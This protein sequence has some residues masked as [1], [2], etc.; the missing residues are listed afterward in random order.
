MMKKIRL[1]QSSRWNGK[2]GGGESMKAAQIFSYNV[3][4]IL[5]V[6]ISFGLMVVVSY[7]FVSRIVE[8][9]IQS[10]IEQ[11]LHTAE[12]SLRSDLREGEMAL[13]NTELFIQEAA[14]AG[15]HLDE[16]Q[17]WLTSQAELL[18][19]PQW[20]KGF[21]DI[22]YFGEDRLLTGSGWTAPV[23]GYNPYVRP[24]YTEAVQAAGDIAVTYPYFDMNASTV[25]TLAKTMHLDGKEIGVL[26][27]DLDFSRI[28][29]FVTELQYRA[30]GYGMLISEDYRFL[31]HPNERYLMQPM[32]EINEGLARASAEFRTKN[33]DVYSTKIVN[34]QG[35]RVV[36]VFRRLF[37]GW[38]LGI[39]TPVTS[40]YQDVQSMALVLSLLGVTFMTI[41]GTFLIRLSLS[42]ARSEAKSR[43]KTSFLARMSH[44][45]RTP[46]NSILGMTELIQ[47]KTTSS[48]VQEYINILYH[49]GQNLLSIINDILDFSRIESNRLQVE[50][51]P[52]HIASV[53]NDTI[54]VIRPR[55]AEKSLDFFVNMDAAIPFELIGDDTRLRQILINLL[56]NAVKYTKTG[57]VSLNISM[58]TPAAES[59]D[60]EAGGGGQAVKLIFSVHDSG[61]GIK[62][63]DMGRLFSEFTRLDARINQ[64]V[65]GTGLGLVISRALCQAMG[66]EVR[67]TSEYGKGSVF[68]ASV[69][70]SFESKKPAAR[71]ENPGAKRALFFD[72]RA[73][74]IYS[75]LANFRSLGISPALVPSLEEFK[76]AL[77]RGEYDFAFI[78]SKYAMDCMYALGKRASPLQLVVLVELGEVSVFREVSSIMMPVYSV[79]LANVIN[80]CADESTAVQTKRVKIHF[81]APSAHILIV[82]DIAT[83]L[84]VAKELMNPY[85][86]NIHTC[87]SGTEAVQLVRQ[88]RYD[89]VFMDH[90]M[91]GMDGIEATAKIRNLENG[92]GYYRTLPIVALTAN[93]V[94]GQ[95]EIFLKSGIN[96]FLAKPIDIQKLD[97]ILG[98]WLPEEKRAEV[99]RRQEDAKMEKAELVIA[100]VDIETGL[101]NMGG[102]L[103]VY[104]DILADF[105]RD[106]ESLAAALTQA[107]KKGD[108]KLYTTLVHGVKGTAR[109]IGALETGES[110]AWL[111]KAAET[112][113]RDIIFEK[114]AELLEKLRVLTENI[115]TARAKITAAQGSGAVAAAVSANLESLK[116]ALIEMD[117]AAANSILLEYAGLSLEG[118]TREKI[119]EIEQH[120]LMYEYDKAIEKID[121]VAKLQFGGNIR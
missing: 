42:K 97:D 93:A 82:D 79:T 68:E 47:R 113:S 116:T 78:S 120:I 54:N 85:N 39:A 15:R 20:L 38:L 105:C 7:I 95:R 106:T 81:T 3:L 101:R 33:I 86:M 12:V 48:E 92:D 11:N 36:L 98:K 21:I 56:A 53:I 74:Y 75:V 57:F 25:I 37:N 19:G 5:F 14:R 69:I 87:S 6:V 76:W 24:W 107:L 4:Q 89:L 110:A 83:N 26:G 16:I 17:S 99:S 121:V 59:G 84:R 80:N 29:A 65:E 60:A 46:M 118:E 108:I 111:E 23:S 51:H 45:I 112:E 30:G 91:P 8:K 90:M 73:S 31:A 34:S 13:L 103:N 67:V 32:E 94:S 2:E 114:N 52:Y 71:V 44:E 70:Q 28:S 66:G 109:S 27:L 88:N 96:D 1:L 77:E 35:M 22:Y 9:E 64:G 10:N 61:V 49:A 117:I 72:E 50:K 41:L 102:S 115:K 62:E 58:E 63:E 40:Y 43:E 119:A 104:I 100:G 55:A 18:R